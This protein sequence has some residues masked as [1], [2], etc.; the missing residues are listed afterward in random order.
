MDKFTLWPILYAVEEPK[1]EREESIDGEIG[2]LR[3]ES[4]STFLNTA[5]ISPGRILQQC[6]KKP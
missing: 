3:E 5:K 6:F 4:N 2:V 1:N